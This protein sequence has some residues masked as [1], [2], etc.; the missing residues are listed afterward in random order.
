MERDDFL[1]RAKS[2][3][4]SSSADNAEVGGGGGGGGG[5]IM[6]LVVV[7]LASAGLGAGNETRAPP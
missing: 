2:C 4:R 5:M 3:G 7:V 1:R 6:G